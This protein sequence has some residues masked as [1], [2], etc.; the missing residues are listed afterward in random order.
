MNKKLKSTLAVF[1]LTVTI[2][3]TVNAQNTDTKSAELLAALVGEN[4]GYKALDAKK[5]VEYYFIYDNFAKGKD[6][7]TE[8]YIF[9]GEQG[10]GFV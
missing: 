10:M 4:G 1:L 9:N 5:D 6:V 7:S 3:T 8:R 2:A